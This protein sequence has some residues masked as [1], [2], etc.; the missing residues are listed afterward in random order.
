MKT[1]IS[2]ERLGKIT[3]T[4]SFWTGQKNIAIE[5]KNIVK[6]TKNQFSDETGT[7]Y[8]LKGNYLTGVVMETGTDSVRLSP[9]VK[10][11]EIVLS[12]LPFILIMVFS[13]VPA[14]F[15]VFPVVGG[16]IGGGISAVTSCANLAIIKCVRNVWLKILITLGMIALT[17]LICF[18][19]ALIILALS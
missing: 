2:H 16:A 15:E 17:L 12:V 14:I 11:Y 5:G 13:N 4:E 8:N 9:S 19:I 3:Y 18:L 7:I 10:W 6:V 1:E